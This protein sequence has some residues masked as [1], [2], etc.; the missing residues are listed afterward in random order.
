MTEIGRS[1][2]QTLLVPISRPVYRIANAIRDRFESEPVEEARPAGEILQENVALKQQVQQL[3]HA[4]E[5][6]EQRAGASEPGGIRKPV[7]PVL[8]ERGG[9][10]W[11]RW[12]HGRRDESG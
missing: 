2:V 9:Q 10:R 11:T 4:I 7:R 3:S 1:P 6:L 12:D 8:G 5:D